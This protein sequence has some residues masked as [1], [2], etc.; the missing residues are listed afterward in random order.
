MLITIG[1]HY[2][3]V[4]DVICCNSLL[5]L[6]TYLLLWADVWHSLTAIF[7]DNPDKVVPECLHCGLYWSLYCSIGAKDD[8]GGDD[9]WSY[10]SCK[11]PVKSSPPTN[12]H[13][14]F[15][16]SD[17]LPVAQPTVSMHWREKY[18]VTRTCSPQ[19]HRASL[20]T[21]WLTTKGTW[22]PWGGLPSLLSAVWCQYPYLLLREMQNTW[23]RCEEGQTYCDAEV[24]WHST[25]VYVCV[26]VCVWCV[27]NL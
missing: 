12:H 14:M 4:F 10:K 18:H 8:E 11:A 27:W 6:L 9:I 7:H 1:D 25:R 20:P 5:S 24:N 19:A 13:P 26:C 21:F 16:R 22:L 15:Y 17:A 3:S 2:C 23:W